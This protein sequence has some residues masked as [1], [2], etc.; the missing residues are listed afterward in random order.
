MPCN[1]R[2]KL[3]VLLNWDAATQYAGLQQVIIEF[4]ASC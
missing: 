1:L 2:R 4:I 3:A